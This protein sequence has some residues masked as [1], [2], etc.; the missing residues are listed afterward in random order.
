MV[1]LEDGN[2]LAEGRIDRRYYCF[3]EGHSISYVYGMYVLVQRMH[4]GTRHRA[5]G[6][7]V[8]RAAACNQTECTWYSEVF[9]KKIDSE[10]SKEAQRC[11]QSRHHV[12]HV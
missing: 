1:G 2:W 6:S 4:G 9:I 8:P 11:L 3:M 12:S 7:L 5:S 10:S